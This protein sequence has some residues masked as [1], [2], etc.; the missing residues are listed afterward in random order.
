MALLSATSDFPINKLVNYLIHTNHLLNS[1]EHSLGYVIFLEPNSAIFFIFFITGIYLIV[2]H[3]SFHI[4]PL[5]FEWSSD[6]YDGSFST[7]R[8]NIGISLRVSL[9]RII[10]LFPLTTQHFLCYPLS[11]PNCFTDSMWPVHDR[12]PNLYVSYH[13][14]LELHC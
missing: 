3:P 7:H 2:I 11:N 13:L 8:L 12:L 6:Y 10:P 4:L 5:D 9:I 1:N 14:F